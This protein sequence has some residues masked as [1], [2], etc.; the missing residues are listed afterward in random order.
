M[1]TI[2]ISCVFGA[3]TWKKRYLAIRNFCYVKLC[4]ENPSYLAAMND[5]MINN[6]NDSVFWLTVLDI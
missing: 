5:L 3:E 2:C 1:M 6:F 4:S